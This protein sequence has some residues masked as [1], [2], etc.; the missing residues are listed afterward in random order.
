MKNLVTELAQRR[1]KFWYFNNIGL[2]YVDIDEA[3]ST[4]DIILECLGACE[5]NCD[6]E[7]SRVA[8]VNEL[9]IR[10]TKSIF[11]AYG[12]QSGLYKKV[13]QTQIENFWNAGNELHISTSRGC[14]AIRTLAALI[15]WNGGFK[16]KGDFYLKST[17]EIHNY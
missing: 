4:E 13:T 12:V 17:D 7:L 5:G 16:H 1:V 8:D 11:K 9:T 3:P 6:Y 14:R 2:D 10:K 15:K